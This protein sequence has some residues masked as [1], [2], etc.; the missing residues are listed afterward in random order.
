MRD[1]RAEKLPVA[2]VSRVVSLVVTTTL[3]GTTT[4]MNSIIRRIGGGTLPHLHIRFHILCLLSGGHQV[5]SDTACVRCSKGMLP[6][7]SACGWNGFVVLATSFGFLS[8]ALQ[9][10]VQHSATVAL[11]LFSLLLVRM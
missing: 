5:P 1:R 11:S 2:C 3:L 8:P 7:R 9:L 6:T 4:I 10:P